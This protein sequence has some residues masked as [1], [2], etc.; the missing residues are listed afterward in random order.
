[1]PRHDVIKA[2]G[3]SPA[4]GAALSP[5]AVDL[6]SESLL[7]LPLADG[8]SLINASEH[9]GFSD[10]GAISK[11][12]TRLTLQMNP[13]A[14]KMNDVGATLVSHGY[15]YFRAWYIKDGVVNYLEGQ[16]PTY[17]DAY[18]AAEYAKSKF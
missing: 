8:I 15:G 3:R 11:I 4:V 13:P 6:R 1:M 12:R 9:K 7:G 5:G 18:T 17:T 14:K 16:Y 2:F 10:Q